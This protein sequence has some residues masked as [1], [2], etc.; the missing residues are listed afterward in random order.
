MRPLRSLSGPQG[1]HKAL[2]GLVRPL[3]S[4]QARCNALRGLMWLL[5][6]LQ[7]PYRALKGLIRP[8][9]GLQ[10]PYKDLKGLIRPLALSEY[11][12]R[13]DFSIQERGVRL[14][15]G[16]I[17]RDSIRPLEGILRDP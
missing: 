9:Q 2:E 14:G 6:V 11:A 12:A 10:G 13:T 16:F 5:K 1:L 7:G 17:L 4:L 3:K 8:L 15:A